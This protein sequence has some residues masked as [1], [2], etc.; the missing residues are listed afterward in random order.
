MNSYIGILRLI[1]A[2]CGLEGNGVHEA[3]EQGCNLV[4]QFKLALA[5]PLNNLL[6]QYKCM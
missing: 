1:W 6:I 5:S 2:E 4:S 3:H